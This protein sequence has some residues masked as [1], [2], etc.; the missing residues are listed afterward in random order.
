M[1]R[2]IPRPLCAGF[3]E[4]RRSPHVCPVDLCAAV[5][6]AFADDSVGARAISS[7]R[8]ERWRSTHTTTSRLGVARSRCGDPRAQPMPSRPRSNSFGG[9]IDSFAR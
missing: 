6:R 9:S 8:S 2:G 7:P 5:H 3:R 1:A 4:T